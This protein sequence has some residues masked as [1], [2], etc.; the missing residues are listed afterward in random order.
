MSHGRKVLLEYT[1]QCSGPVSKWFESWR[2]LRP[3]Y[4][5]CWPVGCSVNTACISS[6]DI[7]TTSPYTYRQ[8]FIHCLSQASYH[9]FIISEYQLIDV[10][11]FGALA[12]LSPP[13]GTKSFCFNQPQSYWWELPCEK[14]NFNFKSSTYWWTIK[15]RSRKIYKQLALSL[16]I[17]QFI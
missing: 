14:K 7:S 13:I 2:S 6:E 3:S 11:S 16:K 12:A 10:H 15:L 5:H 9:L 4:M 17:T 8:P 1:A